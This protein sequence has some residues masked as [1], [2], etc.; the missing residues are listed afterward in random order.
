MI[1]LLI[2]AALIVVAFIAATGFALGGLLAS[3]ARTLT[4]P[5]R[6]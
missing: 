2:L 3:I 5:P 4:T 6:L 1:I